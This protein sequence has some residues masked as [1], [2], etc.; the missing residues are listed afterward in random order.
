MDRDF[1][2]LSSSSG[3]GFLGRARGR[4]GQ[5]WQVSK[6]IPL[7]TFLLNAFRVERTEW[8]VINDRARCLWNFNEN[9]EIADRSV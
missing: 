9:V 4:E 2:Q 5:S 3:H 7:D 8:A 1:R 6:K